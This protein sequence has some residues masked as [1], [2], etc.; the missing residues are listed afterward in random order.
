MTGWQKITFGLKIILESWFYLQCFQPIQAQIHL[1][2]LFPAPV[3][4]PEWLEISYLSESTPSA[5]NLQGWFIQDEKNQPKTI[6]QFDTETWLQPHQVLFV[7]LPSAQLNNNGDGVKLYDASQNLI[8]QID[9]D[10]AISG[11]SW[12]KIGSTWIWTES[13][14][15]QENSSLITPS[16]TITPAVTNQPQPTSTATPTP[17]PSES[18]FGTIFLSEIHPCPSENQEWVEIS[19]DDPAAIILAGWQIQD[20]AGH[21]FDLS[22]HHFTSNW[23]VIEFDQLLNNSGDTIFLLDP[24]LKIIDQTSYGNCLVNQSWAWTG[25]NWQ[26]TAIK[27]PAAAN[28]TTSPS[29]TPAASLSP[30]ASS[31]ATSLSPTQIP[32]TNFPQWVSNHSTNQL[33]TKFLVPALIINPDHLQLATSSSLLAFNQPLID[34]KAGANVIIGGLLLITAGGIWLS[35]DHS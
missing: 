26:W 13:S 2:E 32:P 14:P 34:L 6:Y 3:T 15:N 23:L 7:E 22:D 27:T 18:N 17:L 19:T 30:T 33:T 9:Y 29:S 5:I 21:S 12:A 31:A 4:G 35:D 28:L 25:T 1:T 11:L 24:A 16:P 8:D 10:Q 20:A